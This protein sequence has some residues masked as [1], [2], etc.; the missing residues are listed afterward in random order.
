MVTLKPLNIRSIVHQVSCY[1]SMWESVTFTNDPK[2]PS[3]CICENPFHGGSGAA[4]D[5]G[6]LLSSSTPFLRAMMD[7]PTTTYDRHWVVCSA[8]PPT[9]LQ[10]ATRAMEQRALSHLTAA[11]GK[12]CEESRNSPFSL[13]Q[14]CPSHNRS[15]DVIMYKVRVE[16]SFQN[17]ANHTLFN[18]L[19]ERN[20]LFNWSKKRI[21]R[22]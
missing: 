10:I 6:I 4:S 7:S 2:Q 11:L 16:T 3:P 12:L 20:F 21:V 22:S 8:L 9:L 1:S 18:W 5:G 14:V 17:I 19:W 15:V 13:F